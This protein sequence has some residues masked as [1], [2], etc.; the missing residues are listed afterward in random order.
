MPMVALRLWGYLESGFASLS[1]SAVADPWLESHM[2]FV[3][4]S[5]ARRIREALEVAFAVVSPFSLYDVWPI[6]HAAAIYPSA[7]HS[8]LLLV[9]HGEQDSLVPFAHGQSLAA[10][11]DAELFAYRGGPVRGYT[12][13]SYAPYVVSF[14]ERA[15]ASAGF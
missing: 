10:A 9:A 7:G 8:G 13:R 11:A 15:I 6:A 3:S 5:Y 2:P 12:D 4:A 1:L 14:I